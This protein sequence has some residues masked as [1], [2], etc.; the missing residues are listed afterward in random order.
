LALG[1]SSLSEFED[2]LFMKEDL[3]SYLKK[4]RSDAA[5]CLV[6]G[7][8]VAD[9]KREVFIRIAEHLNGLAAELEK[10][11]LKKGMDGVVTTGHEEKADFNL[12][13]ANVS[14]P[15]LQYAEKPRRVLPWLLGILF[16]AIIATLIFAINPAQTYWSTI[17]AKH[18]PGPPPQDNSNQA[19]VLLLFSSEQA[20]RRLLSDQVAA[21]A[22][23]IGGLESSLDDLK[24]A[25][26]EAVEPTNTA[27]VPAPKAPVT[28]TSPPPVERPVSTAENALES[29]PSPK[30]SDAVGPRGC[31][32]FRSFD[33]RSGTYVT[34]DGRRRQCR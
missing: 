7:S 12:P 18:E 25:R 14:S 2:R 22:E 6:L 23:R 11:I 16:G 19:M 10:S 24:K 34:L 9:E 17:S 30:Q 13:P 28:E 1:S 31:N 3:Q 26:A 27:S 33:P 4:V 8:I 15:P 21:I 5:E 29:P 32:L 20:E